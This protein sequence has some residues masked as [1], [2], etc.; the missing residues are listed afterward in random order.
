MTIYGMSFQ[1]VNYVSYEV[2]YALAITMAGAGIIC[3]EP[4]HS[5]VLTSSAAVMAKF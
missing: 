4:V 3:V 1:L 5:Y 2:F